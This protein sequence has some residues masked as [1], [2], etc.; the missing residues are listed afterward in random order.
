MVC[1][2]NIYTIWYLKCDNIFDQFGIRKYPQKYFQFYYLHE[3]HINWNGRANLHSIELL[4]KISFSV[5]NGD[6]SVSNDSTSNKFK[7]ILSN[8]IPWPMWRKQWH[9]NRP[10]QNRYMWYAI[11]VFQHEIHYNPHTKKFGGCILV[12]LHLSIC[13]SVLHAVSALSRLQFWID[14]FH[15]RHKWSLAWEKVSH[16]MTFDLD[17][18]LQGHSAMTL[19]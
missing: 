14:S 1:K 16:I 11:S 3:W 9:H 13:P 6:I 12:S 15:I 5:W 4:L 19:Q 8:F 2:P 10:S 17:L 7:Y 18:Y